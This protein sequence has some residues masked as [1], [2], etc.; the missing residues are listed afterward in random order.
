MDLAVNLAID[1]K[2]RGLD[3]VDM[4]VRLIARIISNV[5]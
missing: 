2:L 1:E 3:F 4:F 5:H